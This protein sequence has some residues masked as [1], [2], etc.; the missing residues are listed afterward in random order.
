MRTLFCVLEAINGDFNNRL[1]CAIWIRSYTV[2][3]LKEYLRL[4]I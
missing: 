4:R 1:L 3:Y 2:R